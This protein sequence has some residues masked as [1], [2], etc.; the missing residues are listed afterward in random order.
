MSMWSGVKEEKEENVQKFEHLYKKFV[1]GVDWLN[2]QSESERNK[3]K[4]RFKKEVILPMD[5]IWNNLPENIKK[6]YTDIQIS[7]WSRKPICGT[8]EWHR[9]KDHLKPKYVKKNSKLR[10]STQKKLWPT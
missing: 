7:A 10:K 3:H 8:A 1:K 5:E 6:S 4:E 9:Q 2:S